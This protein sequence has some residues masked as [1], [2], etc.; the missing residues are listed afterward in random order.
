MRH[1]RPAQRRQVHPL[2]RPDQGRH[3]GRELPVLHHRAERRHRRAARPAPRRSWRRS[4]SPSASSRRSSSSSTSPAW[5]PARPRAKASATSSSPTSARPTRSSTSCAASR[6]T[7]VIH[8]AG[9]VDP[10]A[11]IEVIQTELCLADLATVEKSAARAT[12]RSPRPAATR[13]RQAPGRRA[14]PSARPRSNEAQPV[15]S[16]AFSKEE[17]AV[18]KPLCLI[19]AK[20]AMFVANVAEDG[21][22]NN[23]LPRPAARLRRQA[24]RAG[25]RDLRQD[26]GRAR[27][28]GRGRPADVPRRDGPGRAGP[29]PPDPRRVHAARPADLLHRRRRRKCAPGRSTSATPRRRRPA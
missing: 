27:R 25:G 17:Q 13:K 5:S 8:V 3:R 18:L 26:R 11:D 21:F 19:T 28:H 6:T 1:R 7:N 9:K 15:R 22:E 23:P 2:Q 12:P 24:A 10:V 29:G 20:P 14:R 4:S 16:I